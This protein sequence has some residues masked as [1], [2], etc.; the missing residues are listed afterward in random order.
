MSQLPD[1]SAIIFDMD[2][3]VLDTET[4]YCIAWQKAAE[5][6]GRDFS[7]D[8]CMSMSGLHSH[9]VEQKLIRQ[10]GVGF[11]LNQFGKLSGQYWREYVNQFGI[12][13][14]KGFFALLDVLKVNNI[15]FCLATNSRQANALECLQLASLEGVFSIIIS[16]DQVKQGKPAADIFLLAAD[17]LMHPITQCLVIEDS[18]TGIQ[19]A[20][21]AEAPSVFI[22][23]VLPYDEAIPKQANCL[24]NDLDE[25]AQIILTSV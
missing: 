1:F 16:R 11:D 15:P 23:S 24:L 14:K 20:V 7:T 9:D 13:V 5:E 25:L 19:A 3:L 10:G 12:P 6:M 22:P 21:N 17:T 18:A 8:F 4:T 2:G